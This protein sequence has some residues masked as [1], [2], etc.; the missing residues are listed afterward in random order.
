M[1]CSFALKRVS[2]LKF[3]FAPV[4]SFG[5]AERGCDR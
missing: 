4:F 2:G 5:K 3:G 1:L